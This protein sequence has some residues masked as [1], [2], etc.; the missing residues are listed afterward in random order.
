MLQGTHDG[1]ADRDDAPAAR[2]A[3][4]VARGARVPPIA[5]RVAEAVPSPPLP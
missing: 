4:A 1:R 2:T 5:S 3:A